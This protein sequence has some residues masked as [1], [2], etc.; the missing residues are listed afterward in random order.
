MGPERGGDARDS[1]GSY[2]GGGGG[3]PEGPGLIAVVL[4]LGTPHLPGL[5]EAG[6]PGQREGLGAGLTASTR[7]SPAEAYF[8]ARLC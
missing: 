5:S 3:R 1:G 8:S 6:A 2:R 7:P 4:S